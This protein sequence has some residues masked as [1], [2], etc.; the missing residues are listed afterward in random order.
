MKFKKI[1]IA[2]NNPK[3]KCYANEGE[4]LI[5]AQSANRM[6]GKLPEDH[7]FFIGVNSHEPSRYGWVSSIDFEIGA[8]DL[9]KKYHKNPSRGLIESCGLL[10]DAVKNQKED[11]P[12][13]CTFSTI[14]IMEK[15]RVLKVHKVF[16][17]GVEG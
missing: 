6:K 3:N 1:L 17:Y 12:I 11:T 5:I 16:F 13:A 4:W 15:K 9:A 2:K 10:L 14:G 7:H 8:E